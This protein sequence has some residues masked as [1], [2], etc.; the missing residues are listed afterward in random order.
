MNALNILSG[1]AAQGLVASLA[2]K[3]KAQ[4]GLDIA[5]EFGAVGAM[6]AKLRAGTSADL[7][8]LTSAMIAD[9][10]RENLVVSATISG[11]GLVETAM[12]VRSGDPKVEVRDLRSRYK[13]VN[14]WNSCCE[15]PAATGHC[16]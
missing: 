7:V 15:S 6:A 2:P 8:V 9:L 4:T 12:A 11:V 13:G 16:R 3:F 10:A 5:G 14:G 1:G